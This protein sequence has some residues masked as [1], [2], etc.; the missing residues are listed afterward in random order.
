MALAMLKWT[1]TVEFLV[2]A[3]Y[4]I[5]KRFSCKRW[6]LPRV[7]LHCASLGRLCY[8]GI[9]QIHCL[10]IAFGR[11]IIVP[12][13]PSKA[14]TFYI[15][16]NLLFQLFPSRVQEAKVVA[17][18][19]GFYSSYSSAK[20]NKILTMNINNVLFEDKVK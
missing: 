16:P 5:G 12:Q 15:A 18:A 20:C 7:S 10:A 17:V 6:I 2:H 4:Q 13:M 1:L 3:T 11:A 8:S 14:S 19:H 9:A